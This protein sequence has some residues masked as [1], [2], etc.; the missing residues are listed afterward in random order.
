M[1]ELKETRVSTVERIGNTKNKYWLLER[2]RGQREGWALTPK[3]M[4]MT[5]MP[6]AA[7]INKEGK[8]MDS[9]KSDLCE[10]MDNLWDQLWKYSKIAH[11]VCRK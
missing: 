10:K 6:S 8:K 2:E 5:M 7:T 1:L 9:L 11:A 3:L 4:M